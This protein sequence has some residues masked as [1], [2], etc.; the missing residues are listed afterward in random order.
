MDHTVIVIAPHYYG[1]KKKESGVM[2]YFSLPN[3][4]IKD[5][6]FPL[7]P[8]PEK[9]RKKLSEYEF[10]IIHV[11]HPFHIGKSALHYAKKLG[12]PCV[13]TYNTLY[14]EFIDIYA[15]F[16]PIFVRNFIE[17]IYITD[18]MKECSVILAPSSSLQQILKKTLPSVHIE[19]IP[20]GVYFDEG[21]RKKNILKNIPKNKKIILSVSRFS[22]EKNIPT[23]LRAVSQLPGDFYLVLVGSG[24][25]ETLL[26]KYASDYGIKNRIIFTGKIPHTYL[27][28]YYRAAD[29]FVFPSLYETQGITLLEAAYF[30]LPVVAVDSPVSREWTYPDF[31]ILTDNTADSLKNGIMQAVKLDKK[32][33]MKT[34]TWVRQFSMKNS[35]QK[36]IKL[37][38]KTIYDFKEARIRR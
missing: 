13:F 18:F 6:P 24:P 35:A 16:L 30:G 14:K 23:V 34:K 37:Y 15:G 9:I 20:T 32:K 8:F 22:P 29:V 21:I 19:H 26:K 4:V 25:H 17:K 5:Y 11:H 3:P 38:E 7:Y 36:L 2:R 31:R 1:Y 10:D 12:I 27:S 28:G 33:A